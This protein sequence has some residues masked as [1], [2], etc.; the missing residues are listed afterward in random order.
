MRHEIPFYNALKLLPKHMEMRLPP[1]YRTSLTP[2]VRKLTGKYFL[3]TRA[4]CQERFLLG[5]NV[6]SNVVHFH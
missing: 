2:M 5:S 3:T 4:R 1:T 6:L